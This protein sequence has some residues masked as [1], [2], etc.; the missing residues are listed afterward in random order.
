MFAIVV[1]LI[2]VFLIIHGQNIDI[3]HKF[4]PIGIGA[5]IATAALYALSMVITRDH[6]SKDSL[7]TLVLLPSVIGAM[8]AAPPMMLVWQPVS[9]WHYQL[10]AYIGVIGTAGY[11]CLTWAYSNS[12]VGRLGLIDYTGLIWATLIGYFI[13][14]EIPSIWTLAGAT[15]IIG[16]CIPTFLKKHYE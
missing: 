2:G 15:M 13:F 1:G 10:I 16:A 8:L 11:I 9:F 7:P 6:S 3:H 12:K 14:Y 5:G 4:D